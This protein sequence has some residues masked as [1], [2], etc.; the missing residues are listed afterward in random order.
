MINKSS[1]CSILCPERLRQVEL[2]TGQGRH[3]RPVLGAVGA[4]AFETLSVMAVDFHHLLIRVY[5]PVFTYPVPL[6]KSKLLLSIFSPGGGRNNLNYQVRCSLHTPLVKFIPITAEDHIR[7]HHR[8]CGIF[9]L[10]G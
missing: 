1:T 5:Y 8:W 4:H 3:S 7:L 6:V 9:L 2:E 10:F